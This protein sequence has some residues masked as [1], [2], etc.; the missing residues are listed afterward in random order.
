MKNSINQ[1]GKSKS[2]G[3]IK[4]KKFALGV[5]GVAVVLF[6]IAIKYI[7]AGH[8]FFAIGWL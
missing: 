3:L 4:M 8:W 5:L 1:E 7:L 6:L 2:A